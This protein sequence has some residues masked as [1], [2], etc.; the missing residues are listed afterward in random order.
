MS[1]F[2]LLWLPL[3]F[4]F[5]TAL[6][7]YEI[8]ISSALAIMGGSLVAVLQFFFGNVIDG[9]A[10]GFERWRSVFFDTVAVPAL[11]PLIVYALF[12][13]IRIARNPSGFGGFALLWLTPAGI[14]RSVQ[15]GVENDPLKLLLVP[16]LWSAIIVCISFFINICFLR[17]TS[18]IESNQSKE[19]YN[20]NNKNSKNVYLRAALE[21]G[22]HHHGGTFVL[23]FLILIAV[24]G[25]V[26]TPPLAATVYWAFYG[27]KQPVLCYG[28]LAAMVI[29]F[30]LSV[31][32]SW[33][34]LSQWRGVSDGACT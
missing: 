9:G 13:L 11:L 8:T 17:H 5:W 26:I 24:I 30:L 12:L 4:L 2:C 33:H 14:L 10:F 21:P 7:P 16:F 29:L 28:S 3:V 22:S 6:V 25:I 31:S 15:W 20:K 23:I 27:Q 18:S 32:I 19:I 34:S 1:V